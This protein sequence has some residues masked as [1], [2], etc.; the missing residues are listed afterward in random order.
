MEKGLY[1]TVGNQYLPH[2]CTLCLKGQVT[3]VSRPMIHGHLQMEIYQQKKKLQS[4]SLSGI[5]VHRHHIYQ[6]HY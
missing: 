2:A 6:Y 3:C 4:Y 1:S 5:S